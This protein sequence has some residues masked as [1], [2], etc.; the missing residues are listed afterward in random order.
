MNKVFLS[1]NI[2]KDPEV[3]YT[4]SG[5]A[6]ARMGI[7]VKRSFGKD[8]V[9][10]FNLVAWE[11]TAEFCGKHF[12]VGGDD[13]EL[14]R[15]YIRE[16]NEG[17][18]VNYWDGNRICAQFNDEEISKSE[19]RDKTADSLTRAMTIALE[20]YQDFCR[21]KNLTGAEYE[22]SL[23]NICRKALSKLLRREAA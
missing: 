15:Y 5:K 10:F 16:N 13:K 17:E 3:R 19:R 18:Y 1:G 12:K 20:H 7:A 4:Q 6:F 8:A 11:K 21:A 22:L 14:D 23:Y 2:T 9:D